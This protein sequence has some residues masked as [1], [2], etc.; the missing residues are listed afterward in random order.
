M[1]TSLVARSDCIHS[2]ST[3]RCDSLVAPTVASLPVAVTLI[4]TMLLC[5]MVIATV[6]CEGCSNASM[7]AFVGHD[8][9]H[10][11]SKTIGYIK[12]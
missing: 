10:W 9:Y 1:V 4:A 12:R 7:E 6:V 8:R 11:A 2:E 3:M 5:V